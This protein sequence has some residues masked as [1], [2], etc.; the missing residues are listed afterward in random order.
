[1]TL[2]SQKLSIIDILH[3]YAHSWSLDSCKYLVGSIVTVNQMTRVTR[4]TQKHSII[5]KLYH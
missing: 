1:M 5:D 3:S 4:A 2:A